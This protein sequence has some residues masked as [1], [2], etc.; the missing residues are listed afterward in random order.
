MPLPSSTVE[1]YLKTIF[2]AQL[3]LPGKSDLV[4]MG[5]LAGALRVVPGTATTMVKALSDAGLVKYEAYA[6]VRLTHA[7]EKVAASVIRRHRLIEMF[8]VKVIGMNWSEVHEEAEHLEHAMSDHLIERIDAMLG[9]PA[10]D[11]ENDPIPEICRG[12]AQADAE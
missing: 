7:G 5:R 12:A 1:N 8:L 3:G 11:P 10:V 4:P 6:G 9:H 2:Q